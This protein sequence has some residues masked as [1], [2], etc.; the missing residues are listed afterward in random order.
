MKFTINEISFLK[1]SVEAVTIK[2][3]DAPAV[4]KVI[5]KVTKEFERLQ[6]M[7]MSNTKEQ[8]LNISK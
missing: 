6:S 7:E 4:A 3:V 1:N 5:E 2:S 8:S